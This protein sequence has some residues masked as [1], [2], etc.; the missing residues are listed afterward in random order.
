MPRQT[1]IPGISDGTSNTL[2]MSEQIMHTVD[3]QPD[4]RGD[5]L[6]DDEQT[7]RFMTIDTPNS[8]IDQMKAATYCFNQPAV[9]LP[10]ATS[11]NG[12]VSARSRHTG[13]VNAS[14]ADGSVRFVRDSIVLTTWQAMST[15]NGGEVF[16]ND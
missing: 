11:P 2:L 16:T 8:G 1:T 4:W 10:C 5:M 3:N 12:K 14:M 13:G 9:G 15:I 6:N 7:G